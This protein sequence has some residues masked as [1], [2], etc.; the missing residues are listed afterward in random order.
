MAR[1]DHQSEK[2]ALLDELVEIRAKII[3][4]C[5]QLDRGL[6]ETPFL[7]HWSI[8]ELLAHLSGWDLANAE[9]ADAILAGRLPAFYK[10]HDQDWKEF[11]QI[12]VQRHI[13]VDFERMLSSVHETQR[14]LIATLETIPPAEFFKDHGLRFKG[15]KVIL[16]RLLTAE[17]EDE[18][19]HLAQIETFIM[20]PH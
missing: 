4:R 11:N 16:S 8:M 13:E 20:Q 18:A 7:G 5:R 15:Y 2:Q 3:D 9:A 6:V 19:E 10:H 12:L 14:T 1:K 17:A